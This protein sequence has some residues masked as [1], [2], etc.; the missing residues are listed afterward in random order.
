[1]LEAIVFAIGMS[2]IVGFIAFLAWSTYDMAKAAEEHSKTMQWLN[3]LESRN[4][5]ENVDIGAAGGDK[6]GRVH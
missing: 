4:E 1:M 5:D 6:G 2:I 3:R